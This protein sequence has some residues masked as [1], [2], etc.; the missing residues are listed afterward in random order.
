MNSVAQIITRVIIYISAIIMASMIVSALLVFTGVSLFKK[1]K[2]TQDKRLKTAGIILIVI[3][4]A[5][6]IVFSISMLKGLIT[7]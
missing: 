2:T 3:G 4:I 1:A 6:A 7:I 5:V